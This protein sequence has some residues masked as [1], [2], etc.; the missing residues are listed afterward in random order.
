MSGAEDDL[1]EAMGRSRLEG[2]VIDWP[3]ERQP[4]DEAEGYRLQAR[5]ADWLGRQG[6]G[7][8][9]GWKVGA[10][11]RVMQDLLSIDHPCAG[12]VLAGRAFGAQ[13]TLLYEQH[14]RP[15]IECEIAVR[16]G[17]DVPPG[18][19]PFDAASIAPYV[20]TAMPAME[21]VDD[22]YGDFRAW[23]PAA[24]IADDFFQSAVVL[25]PEV[26]NWRTFD[27]AGMTG[28]TRID[29]VETGRGSGAEV[30][31]NP[32]A[33]L[34]WLAN[35]LAELGQGL[36]SGQFVLLGSLVAVQWLAGP[37]TAETEIVGLGKVSL[38]LE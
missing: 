19:A 6:W 20:A 34:A 2:G 27:L 22:R 24:L 9:A 8:H 12:T 32:I 30:M 29:G 36:K 11:T 38:T 21:L 35:R 15:G 33:A 1:V 37:A 28:I 25:G 17:S 26:A 3:R 4:E 31:G 5:L 13:P 18:R 14:R 7:R 23:T 16:L 10:T